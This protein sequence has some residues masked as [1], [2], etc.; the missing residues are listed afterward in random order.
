MMADLRR[1]ELASAPLSRSLTRPVHVGGVTV[2]GGAPV[3]VQSMCNTATSDADAS[4]AQ[5]ETLMQAGCE[6]IRLAVPH[7]SALDGF[8]EVCRRSPL[9]VIAD[10]HFDHRLAISAIEAGASAVRINPGNVG[11]WDRVDAVVDAARD[12]GVPLRIGVN[13]GSLDPALAARDDLSLE[14]KMVASAVSYVSHIHGRG[15]EDLVLSAK[16][17]DVPTMVA[18]NR[19]LST[20]L[21]E[22]PLHLGVTEAGTPRQGTIKSS[23]GL[24]ILLAEGIGDTIRVSLTAPPEDELPVAWG[25]LQA[26]GI[27]RRGPEI[28]SCPTC[29]RTEVD[30][31]GLADQV[32]ERLAGITA[33]ISVAVMGCVVNGP[34]EAKDADLGVACGHGQGLLFANGEVVRKVPEEAIVDELMAEV[35]RRYPEA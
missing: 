23:C 20:E 10:I 5:I 8:A 28:V 27:R 18:V 17:H 21:P 1:P 4:L 3:V 6:L 29:G 24:G 13:A 9:P 35:A 15:F 31:V 2:G 32:T 11:G 19:R 14:D 33:P 30:L 22:V 16:A 34:G 26:L 7:A 25:I 12:A